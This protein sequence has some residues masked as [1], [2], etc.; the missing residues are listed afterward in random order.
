MRFIAVVMA[1]LLVGTGCAANSYRIPNSELQRL[2]MIPPET[3]AQRVLVSQELTAT[4]VA[5]AEPVNDQTAIVFVPEFHIGGS[6]SGGSRG[7]GG[8]STGGSRGGAGGLKLSGGGSDGKAAAVAIL[9][10]AA[11]VLVAAAGIEGSRF[12]GWV[13]L[14]PMH[15][16]HL[17][18]KDGSQAVMPLAWI[19]PQAAAWTESA[20]VKPTEGPWLQLD[21][22]P[23]TR[24]FA[25]GLYGGYGSSKSVYGDVDAG[26]SFVIQGG[27]FP[28]QRIGILATVALAWRENRYGGTLFESR[29]MAELQALPIVAGPLHAGVYGGIGLAYRWEDT[30]VGTIA[31]GGLNGNDGSTAMSGGGMLQLD[32]HTRI[33]LTVRMGVVR[34]HGD[35]QTDALVGISVY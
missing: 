3:R 20:I 24:A 19:D 11:V 30:P 34:S 29:Y 18:G 6:Y 7:G 31:N 12:D 9:V 1:G 33:A 22:K 32:L 26:P 16:V 10:M 23:L 15:P 13:R 2:S 27:Y 4:E 17:V 25:Y 8:V 28:D 35:K 14:H 21:R 5:D